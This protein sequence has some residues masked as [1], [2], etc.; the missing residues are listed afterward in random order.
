MNDSQRRRLLDRDEQ[1]CRVYNE[2]EDER[3]LEQIART[4]QALLYGTGFEQH[5][6]GECGHDCPYCWAG[7][8]A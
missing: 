2:T 5:Q 1:L 7:G 4:Q 6:A 8:E 3:I